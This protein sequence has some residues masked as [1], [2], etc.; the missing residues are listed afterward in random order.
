MTQPDF[1]R[2][3]H[4]MIEQ[5]IR[6][7][8]VLH[9]AVLD[10]L[11]VVPRERF[12]PQGWESLAFADAEIPIGEGQYMMSPKLEARLLQSLDPQP[13]ERAL[14]IGTGSGYLTALLARLSRHVT[15]IEYYETL[16]AAARTRL[17]AQGIRNVTL[18]VA[19]AFGQWFAKEE[20]DV[21]AVTG[22]VPVL[23][24]SFREA[25]RLGGRLFVIVG[26]APAMEARL[27]TRIGPEAWATE[28]LF[29]TVVAPLVNAPQPPRFVF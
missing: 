3:R 20:F 7:W 29:E 24:G 13:G 14:E 19:D 8:E 2:A 9:P 17:D 12:V 16:S 11:T 25:L 1:E 10:A 22:S 27:I 15:S 4:N 26:E 28:S 6:P 5:Q 23:P 18:Q 21:I